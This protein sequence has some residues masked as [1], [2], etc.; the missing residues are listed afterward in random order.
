MV[1]THTKV[2]LS[3]ITYDPLEVCG[4]VCICRDV[5]SAC[6]QILLVIP[7]SPVKVIFIGWEDMVFH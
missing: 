7:L 2:T 3:I 4:R 6:R 5:L 1:C